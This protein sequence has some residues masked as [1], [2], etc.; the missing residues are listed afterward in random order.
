MW[1]SQVGGH[2]FGF[3]EADDNEFCEQAYSG[4]GRSTNVGYTTFSIEE[5]LTLRDSD[6]C[7][8]DQPCAEAAGG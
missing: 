2:H 1:R 3:G 7:C 4:D 6:V 5:L 8:R